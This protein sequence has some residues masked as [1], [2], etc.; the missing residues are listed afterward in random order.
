MYQFRLV[1]VWAEASPGTPVLSGRLVNLFWPIFLLVK[2]LWGIL[3]LGLWLVPWG[4]WIDRHRVPAAQPGVRS[5][6]SNG[7]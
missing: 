3:T 2:L 7:G 5:L 6:G 4:R 1:E